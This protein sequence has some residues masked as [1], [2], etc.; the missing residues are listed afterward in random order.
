MNYDPAPPRLGSLR[1]LHAWP[2]RQQITTSTQNTPHLQLGKWQQTGVPNTQLR[3]RFHPFAQHQPVSRPHQFTS[4]H[5][6][7]GVAAAGDAAP[8]PVSSIRALRN[9]RCGSPTKKRLRHRSMPL[10]VASVV[11]ADHPPSSTVIG[12][13]FQYRCGTLRG[14]KGSENLQ[15]SMQP[16]ATT[17]SRLNG[18]HATS[19]PLICPVSLGA[20]KKEGGRGEEA[21]LRLGLKIC[22][23]EEI[24]GHPA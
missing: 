8:R 17:K 1:P 18:R 11:P 22:G 16:H 3:T 4:L 14:Q 9:E 24:G 15:G 6:S 20:W 21:D 19:L 2:V 12:R 5:L 23:H 10:A 13:S 7:A